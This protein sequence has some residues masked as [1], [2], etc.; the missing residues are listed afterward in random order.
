MKTQRKYFVWKTNS[1]GEP[2][3]GTDRVLT[4]SSKKSVVKHL[5]YEE[6]VQYT[7]GDILVKCKNG[8][9]WFVRYSKI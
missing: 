4:G 7:E 3:D 8:D 1:N 5:A 6:G 9:V 2:I